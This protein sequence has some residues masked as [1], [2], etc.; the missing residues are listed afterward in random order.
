[1]RWVL[2]RTHDVLQFLLL[3]PVSFLQFMIVFTLHCSES[4]CRCKK[5]LKLVSGVLCVQVPLA[6]GEQMW[7]MT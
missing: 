3:F 4:S 6:Y 5:L 7:N 1:M 2:L